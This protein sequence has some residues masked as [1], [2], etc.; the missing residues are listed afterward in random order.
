MSPKATGS[1]YGNLDLLVLRALELEG[2]L[3]GLGVMDL[4]RGLSGGKIEVE[5]GAL[6]R[7]L[8]RLEERS[9]LTSE[10]RTSDAN[11]R[12]KFYTL[13]TSGRKELVR[14]REEWA[15]HAEAIGQVLGLDWKGVR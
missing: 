2:P 8:H 5:G 7:S 11:R 14:A 6:Y 9:L 4:I 1:L 12:A 13:A 15:R 10:W 3:H